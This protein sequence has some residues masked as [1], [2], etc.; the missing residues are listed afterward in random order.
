MISLSNIACYDTRI[1]VVPLDL[2][3][4]HNGIS[5]HI[6]GFSGDSIR[7]CLFYQIP[8]NPKDYQVKEAFLIDDKER[9]YCLTAVCRD[10]KRGLSW[11][12]FGPIP[13][14]VKQL[15]LHITQI[16]QAPSSSFRI[17][18]RSF[19]DP[20]DPE[21]S[22]SRDII[23]RMDKWLK[24]PEPLQDV[25][26][27]RGQWNFTMPTGTWKKEE[28]DKIKILDYVLPLGREKIYFKEFRNSNTGAFVVFEARDEAL[29]R[30]GDKF[31][32]LLMEKFKASQNLPQFLQELK[33]MGVDA[34]YDP[35]KLTLRLR[36]MERDVLYSPD[37][38]DPWGV[39]KNRIYHFFDDCICSNRLEI[40]IKEVKDFKFSPAI[41]IDLGFVGA[42]EED[43]KEFSIDLDAGSFKI[44][45]QIIFY[46]P[47]VKNGKLYMEYETSMESP[48]DSLSIRDAE[49]IEVESGTSFPLM[50]AK[51]EFDSK[52]E[53]LKKILLF[54]EGKVLG[55]SISL[56]LKRADIKLSRPITFSFETQHIES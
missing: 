49:I 16:Q 20:W 50:G 6:N 9:T 42:W 12:E 18:G 32:V 40:I 24:E 28:V 39:I 56:R 22:Y 7:T 1:I 23:A 27:I 10:G 30:I 43:H 51:R 19:V 41:E 8:Q 54:P 21:L 48:L 37:F 35:V 34:G 14:H 52:K 53:N 31:S 38:V 46:E 29:Q 13:P 26:H 36:D 25:W 11:M 4:S 47:I 17:R 3:A 15:D 55:K 44:K 5:I 2:E 45:G 33:D